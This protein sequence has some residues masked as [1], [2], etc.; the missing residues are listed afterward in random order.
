[1]SGKHVERMRQAKQKAIERKEL[2]RKLFENQL[3]GIN[4]ADKK[5]LN[6]NSIANNKTL[7]MLN[8]AAKMKRSTAAGHFATDSK[9]K[10]R[11]K[12][13]NRLLAGRNNDRKL[14]QARITIIVA[15]STTTTCIHSGKINST[16]STFESKNQH[17]GTLIIL[18]FVILLYSTS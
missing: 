7:N 16:T 5:H 10:P 6:S 13:T 15:S 18:H 8:N 9:T 4:D 11:S 12:K 14:H 17:T 3:L 1:M 2:E